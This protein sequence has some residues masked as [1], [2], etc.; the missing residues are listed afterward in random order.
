M[1]DS[2]TWARSQQ[3][4][5]VQEKQG[6]WL[7]SKYGCVRSVFCDT[8]GIPYAFTSCSSTSKGEGELIKYPLTGAK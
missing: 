7:L 3:L 1:L 4:A 5:C 8:K 6:P 2:L